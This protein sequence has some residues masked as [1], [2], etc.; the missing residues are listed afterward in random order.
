MSITNN[1]VSYVRFV[2]FILLRIMCQRHI[3]FPKSFWLMS[4]A[5]SGVLLAVIFKNIRNMLLI[6]IVAELAF[7]YI[8]FLFRHRQSPEKPIVK[9]LKAN[10]CTFIKI[11][12]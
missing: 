10:N 4:Y 6:S 7:C 2:C 9:I 5:D 11:L 12:L 3:I 8:F 1:S